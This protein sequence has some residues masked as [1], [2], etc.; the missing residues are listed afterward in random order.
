MN[1]LSSLRKAAEDPSS[2]CDCHELHHLTPT[3]T[4]GVVGQ[5][6]RRYVIHETLETCHLEVL[7]D[8]NV[9]FSLTRSI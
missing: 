7:C 4:F 5:T 9:K 8:S 3:S 1:V 2:T 6:V